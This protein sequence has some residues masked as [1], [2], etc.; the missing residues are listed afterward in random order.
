MN[1]LLRLLGIAVLAGLL[2]ACAGPVPKVDAA[3][4][5]LATIKTVAVIRAPEPKTYA[6]MN[7]GHPG[8]A[9]GLVGGLI[10]AADQSAKQDRV[11]AAFKSQGAKVNGNLAEQLVTRL[12]A[13]GYDARIEDGPWEEA[14]GGYKLAFDKIDSTAD[15]VL[16]ASPAVVG[17]VAT[18][19]VS[20]Y[21][22]TMTVVA[23]LFLGKERKN[24]LY[25]GFHSY[26]WAPKAEGWKNS[27]PKKTFANFD[28]VMADT[29]SA[30]TALDDAGTRLAESV[31]GDLRR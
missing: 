5:K 15:A 31:A 26:G 29:K 1:S 13:S 28:A 7:F 21:M 4:S 23:S 14:D 20:D 3:A 18:G 16:V 11:S 17:F 25:R 27:A 6:V 9:F 8:M 19:A 10:A 22:P 24:P 30:Q 2:A 12:Q